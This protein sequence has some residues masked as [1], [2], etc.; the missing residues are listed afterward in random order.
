MRVT[1]ECFL[2]GR[3]GRGREEREEG[4]F[5]ERGGVLRRGVFAQRGRSVEEGR[6]ERGVC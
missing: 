6:E 1:S 3:E 2:R 5:A 4:V